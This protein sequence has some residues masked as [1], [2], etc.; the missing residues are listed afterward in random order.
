MNQS[1]CR[2]YISI[3]K[4]LKYI[5]R[6]G[7]LRGHRSNTYHGNNELWYKYRWLI[8]PK[9]MHSKICLEEKLAKIVSTCNQR[10]CP[11]VAAEWTSFTLSKTGEDQDTWSRVQVRM[12]P[13]HRQERCPLFKGSLFFIGGSHLTEFPWLSLCGQSTSVSTLWVM[14]PMKTWTLRQT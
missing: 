2:P 10:K 12:S 3:N 14:N 11:L 8:I 7:Q 9:K 6:S 5:K 1:V 4:S 13:V